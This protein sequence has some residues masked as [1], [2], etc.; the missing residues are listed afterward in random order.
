MELR[1][2]GASH[3]G[4]VRAHNEDSFLLVPEQRLYLVAD[5]MGGHNAG[6]VAS[7]LAVEAVRDH[8]LGTADVTGSDTLKDEVP[9]AANKLYEALRH[10]NRVVLSES[11]RDP[12]KQGMGTTLVAL[13]FEAGQ[14]F[15]AHLGDSRCYRLRD[16][17]F[18]QLTDDHSLP[19]EQFRSG[20]LSAE[21]AAR[22]PYRNVITRACGIREGVRP[23]LFIDDVR[24]GDLFLLCSD[25]L[26]NELADA[27]IRALLEGERKDL[28]MA[29]ARLIDAAN[30]HGGMDN[31][32]VL[33][34]E[35]G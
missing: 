21:E 8:F 23:D 10:A 31:I 28:Q 12:A 14:V 7:R 35:A 20:L 22:S 3:T 1:A 4:R 30:A 18:A 11:E 26:N 25:G 24:A 34:V 16:G 19:Q 32:T 33:I 2:E 29:C 13:H 5:G 27:E 15:L 6:E 17:K 9:P